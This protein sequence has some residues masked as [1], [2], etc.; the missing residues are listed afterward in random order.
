MRSVASVEI[1]GITAGWRYAAKSGPGMPRWGRCGPC[2][3]S[4]WKPMHEIS[5]PHPLGGTAQILP[6]EVYSD[7]SGGRAFLSIRVRPENYH[8]GFSLV[9]LRFPLRPFTRLTASGALRLRASREISHR[10]NGFNPLYRCRD[11]RAYRRD[12]RG[13]PLGMQLNHRTTVS[14]L[15]SLLAIPRG[16]PELAHGEHRNAHHE[17][18]GNHACEHADQLEDSPHPRLR[19]LL[20]DVICMFFGAAVIVASLR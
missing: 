14:E 8:R 6:G 3:A 4:P 2:E 15:L 9:K 16:M 17:Q 12:A 10:S 13:Q 19:H 20:R 1:Y 5:V 11:N 7:A 18:H